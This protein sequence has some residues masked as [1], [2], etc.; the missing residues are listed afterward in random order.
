MTAGA[1]SSRSWKNP[2][3]TGLDKNGYAKETNGID[4]ASNGYI[5]DVMGWD[6]VFDDPDPDPYIFDGMDATKIQPYWHSIS[7]M[8]IIGAK[9]NNGIGVAGINRSFA[10]CQTELRSSLYNSEKGVI[11][12]TGPKSFCL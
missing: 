3:E 9:G 12:R 10:G 2:G 8:G 1:A 6:F 5:D 4:D 11:P 7:A